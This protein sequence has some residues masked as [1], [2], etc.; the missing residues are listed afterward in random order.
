MT[1]EIALRFTE[2]I[3]NLIQVIA[4]KK[5]GDFDDT[6]ERLFPAEVAELNTRYREVTGRDYDISRWLRDVK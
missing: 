1:D 6:A 2:A 5:F 3:E 4:F